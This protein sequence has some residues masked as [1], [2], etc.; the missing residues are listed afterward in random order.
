[1]LVTMQFIQLHSKLFLGLRAD[2]AASFGDVP[3]YLRPFVSL[4]GAPIMQ[5]Q[6]DDSE[7][8]YS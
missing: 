5:Y 2:G 1:M 7:E 4:R 3:F 6:G 8:N